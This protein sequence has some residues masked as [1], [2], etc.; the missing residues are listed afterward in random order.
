MH[1]KEGPLVFP[2]TS[3][4]I[5]SEYH[6]LP[7]NW[8]PTTSAAVAYGH[9]IAPWLTAMPIYKTNLRSLSIAGHLN[10]FHSL[11][12]TISQGVVYRLIGPS[13][14]E[15]TPGLMEKRGSSHWLWKAKTAE[16]FE[17]RGIELL[18]VV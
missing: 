17:E 16:E 6:I 10:W 18:R 4:A 9:E 8:K 11:R 3:F 13:D 14:S 2:D 12:S 5:V 7:F 15:W 1:R